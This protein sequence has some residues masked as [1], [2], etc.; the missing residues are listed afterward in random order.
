MG[1]RAQTKD[2]EAKSSTQREAVTE[3]VEHVELA[4]SKKQKKKTQ[5]HEKNSKQKSDAIEPQSSSTTAAPTL[6]SLRKRLRDI[7]RLLTKDVPEEVRTTKE[8]ELVDV[9]ELISQ[10]KEKQA[11][12]ERERKFQ[13]KY[14]MVRF[15]EKKKATR[16]AKQ[17][18]RKLKALEE[19]KASSSELKAARKTLLE[20]QGDVLYVTHFPRDRPYVSLFPAEDTAESQK[21]RNE[22]RA[23]IL[24]EHRS[25]HL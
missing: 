9:E 20:R 4:V 17:A 23:S 8:K 5:S 7:K 10:L 1:K 16:R 25:E 19:S 18:A 12:S 22:V 15:F 2:K 14:R 13:T 6:M 11:Q 21:Q 24:A 3:Q